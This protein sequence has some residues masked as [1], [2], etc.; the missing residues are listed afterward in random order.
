MPGRKYLLLGASSEVV[1]AF[2]RMHKWK[3]DDEVIAQYFSH[4]EALEELAE[5]IPARVIMR[6]A[7][8]L[9]EEGINDF[10]GFIREERFTPTHIL[11]APAFP[12]RNARLTELKWE[13]FSV[14]I[15]IQV[16]AFFE[17]MRS[18]V[19]D[20]GKSGGG[21]IAVVLSSSCVGV[22]PAFLSDY[23]TAKYAL[24]GLAKAIAS[25]YASKK[26]QVNMISPSMMETKF[27]ADIYSGVSEQSAM[28]NP[29]KR[30]AKPEDIA[31]LVSYLFSDDNTFITGANIPVTGGEIF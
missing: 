10:T 30:N 29:M 5:K 17:V 19:R 6:K 23:I 21:K 13:N 18:V 22:P 11:H 1:L 16:R 14:Q 4:K 15:M 7:D 24:M 12:V 28:N 20:M 27:I 26:I 25:E 31:G 8:F 3:P 2:M 9:S